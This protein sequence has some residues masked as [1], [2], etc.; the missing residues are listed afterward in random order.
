MYLG[1]V[2]AT[3][4][5]LEKAARQQCMNDVAPTHEIMGILR[6]CLGPRH[7]HIFPTCELRHRKPAQNAFENKAV[8]LNHICE[9]DSI[10]V[11]CRQEDSISV[12][13]VRC[14]WSLQNHNGCGIYARQS[15][16]A[17]H[18]QAHESLDG[19]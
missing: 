16:V 18:S 2:G 19:T 10:R 6:C 9:V 15:S 1:A 3:L 7:D 13:A 5:Y 12:N 14:I 11:T 17:S 8:T 4:H